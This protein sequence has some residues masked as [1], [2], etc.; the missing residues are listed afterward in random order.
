MT[1]GKEELVS[2]KDESAD[3]FSNT[4][5]ACLKLDNTLTIKGDSAVCVYIYMNM[6]VCI[7]I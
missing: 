6:S 2:P 4:M 7:H 3:L 1:V 5:W